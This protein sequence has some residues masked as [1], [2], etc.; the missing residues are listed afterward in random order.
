VRLLGDSCRYFHLTVP[1][2]LCR[3]P[4]YANGCLPAM[5][6]RLC[7]LGSCGSLL[8]LTLLSL[9]EVSLITKFGEPSCIVML[10]L[11]WY[12]MIYSLLCC[13]MHTHLCCSISHCC[14]C[15]GYRSTPLLYVLVQTN[16]AMH[17]I[18][19]VGFV[20]HHSLTMTTV[21][22]IQLLVRFTPA[23]RHTN[24]VRFLDHHYTSR[25]ISKPTRDLD[26]FVAC[27]DSFVL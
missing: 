17:G 12:D 13:H 27:L 22:A 7:W 1:F 19:D 15:F 5:G 8:Y 25:V 23:L 2:V 9:Q 14:F 26:T 10:A 6:N 4:N 21:R 11:T 18:N 20:C 3:L 16:A 24:K